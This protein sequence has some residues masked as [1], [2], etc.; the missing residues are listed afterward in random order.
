VGGG[1][2]TDRRSELEEIRMRSRRAAAVATLTAT[3]VAAGTASAAAAQAGTRVTVSHGTRVTS[4]QDRDYVKPANNTWN[5]NGDRDYG[6]SADRTWN[7]NGD[8]D[9]APAPAD[10]IWLRPLGHVRPDPGDWNS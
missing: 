1:R 3:I 10:I 9:I 2:I 4:P 7:P 8:R 6:N 5:P